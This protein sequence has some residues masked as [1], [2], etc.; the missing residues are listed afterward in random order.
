MPVVSPAKATCM[1]TCGDCPSE[2]P[3]SCSPHSPNANILAVAA[4]REGQENTETQCLNR[5][6]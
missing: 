2:S 4:F 6:R 3:K 1:R 5:D